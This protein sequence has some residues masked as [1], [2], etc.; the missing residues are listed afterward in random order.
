MKR[1]LLFVLLSTSCSPQYTEVPALDYLLTVEQVGPVA[2]RDPIGRVSPDGRWLAYTE[3]DYIHIVPVEGGA[4]QVIGHGRSSIRFLTWLPDSRRL[5]VRERLFDRSRQEWWIYD[6]VGSTREPL[7]PTRIDVP[8]LL[9]L[10]MLAW[11]PDGR[12]VAAI[13]GTGDES[14]VWL[15]DADGRNPQEYASKER[16]SFPAWSPDGRLGCL[17][18]EDNRQVVYFPCDASSPL[19]IDQEVYGPFAFS[20]DG[21]HL[22]YGTPAEK[23]F[24][25]LWSRPAAGGDPMRLVR[26]SRDAYAP[27]VGSNDRIVFKSQDYRVFIAM[28]PADGGPSRPITTFQSETPSWSWS[29]LEVAF[30]F[31]DW[32]HVTDDFHYPDIAQDIGVV[33][34]NS[35]IPHEAPQRMVRQ[36]SSEDQG[37]HWS[38]NGRWIVFHTHHEESDDIWLMPEDGSSEPRMISESGNETGWA[39]WSP[40]GEWIV[41]PSYRR[42]DSGARQAQLFIIGIDQET[43]EVTMPQAPVEMFVVPP[44]VLSA[45]IDFPYDVIH[46]EWADSGEALVFEAAEALGRKSLWTIPRSGGVPIRF[47]TFTSDQVHS[48]I[49]VSPDGRWAAYVDRADDG[50]F[51]IFRVPVGGGTAEQVTYDPSDKTQ[52]AYA[53]T[54]DRIAFTVFDYR[55]HFWQIEP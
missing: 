34:V 22:Y 21:D 40:D 38:P 9:T 32:R 28:A 33:T 55:T 1:A 19:F 47:H 46:G 10:D 35:A 25:D 37:M 30:T 29:G 36:S 48:G 4:V 26:F 39:R 52:P 3:R 50:H 43:G 24:L 20:P 11:S 2:Y 45:G 8:D 23:G 27:S 12:S 18:Y 41:F 5:A 49:S 53:P 51:Q 13:S 16:L 7:W 31:G 14:T 54:G 44:D 17:S 6:R 42:N 15:I